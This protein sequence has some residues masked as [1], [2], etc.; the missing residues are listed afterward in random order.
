M[1]LISIGGFLLTLIGVGVIVLMA[2]FHTNLG[3]PT[4]IVPL[5]VMAGSALAGVCIYL[6]AQRI[7][8][9]RGVDIAVGY[10]SLPAD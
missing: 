5:A 1:P 3:D 8:A 10:K 4:A 7:Q 2:I 9:Q 6:A